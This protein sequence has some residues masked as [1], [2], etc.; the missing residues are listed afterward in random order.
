[1]KAVGYWAAA[2]TLALGL[3]QTPES[4][5]QSPHEHAAAALPFFEVVSIEPYAPN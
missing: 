5:A 3:A 1:M 4:R 2:I